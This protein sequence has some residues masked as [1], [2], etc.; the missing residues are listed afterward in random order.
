MNDNIVV[1]ELRKA[2]SPLPN[3]V[4]DR[5]ILVATK[6]TVLRAT[7]EI[8]ILGKEILKVWKDK[9]RMEKI[10]KWLKRE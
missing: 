6:G 5:E 8:H 10:V 4:T 3:D 7:C 1:R 2:L 9:L